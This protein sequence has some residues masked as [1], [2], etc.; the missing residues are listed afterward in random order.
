VFRERDEYVARVLCEASRS[1]P[2]FKLRNPF[3]ESQ[4]PDSSGVEFIDE[5]GGRPRVRRRE[6]I[7]KKPGKQGA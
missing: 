2:V 1:G 3:D 4:L 6:R 5:N 7:H